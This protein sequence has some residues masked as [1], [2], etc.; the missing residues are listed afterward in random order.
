M[1]PAPDDRIIEE[2]ATPDGALHLYVVQLKCGDIAMG[3]RE[4]VWLTYA[5]IEA[6]VYGLPASEAIRKWVDAITGDRVVIVVARRDGRIVDAWPSD[7]HESP[8]EC[9]EYARGCTRGEPGGGLEYRWWS[10]RAET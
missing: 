4:S 2:H 5:D 6:Q 3:F 9:R 1:N 8:A 10:G 7:L